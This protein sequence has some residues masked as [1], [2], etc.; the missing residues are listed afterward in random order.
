MTTK[1]VL[2]DVGST[3]LFPQPSVAETFA[4]VAQGRG[5]ALTVRDVEPHMQAVDAFYEAEYLR[6]GDFWCSPEGCTEIWLDQYRYLAHLSGVAHDAEGI[7]RAVHAAFLAPGHWA[8]YGD[9]RG[10]L[11]ALKR[12]GLML[13]VVS[14]W[15]AH[16]EELLRGLGLL[17]YFDDVVSSAVVGYRKPDP[18]TFRLALEHLGVSA[19]EAVH[20][21]DR[22]DADGDGAAA[23][24]IRPLI[25]DRRG[26]EAACGYECVRSLEE[27][28]ARL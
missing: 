3:L 24:G 26:T 5:H 22:P 14:N 8:L 2:F 23:A 15:D 20:V 1:A 11:R 7:A 9:V 10:C 25:I 6:D 21:G 17:P 4:A 16:L 18:V 12:R 27:V 28:P 19:A 13:G